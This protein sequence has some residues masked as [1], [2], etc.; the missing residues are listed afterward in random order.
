[1]MTHLELLDA[2]ENMTGVW[3]WNAEPV[4]PTECIVQRIFPKDSGDGYFYYTFYV[5]KERASW[6]TFRSKELFKTQL[7]LLES[8]QDDISRRIQLLKDQEGYGMNLWPILVN[9]YISGD[10]N[11]EN[12]K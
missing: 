7:E 5:H 10:K 1:M 4:E 12:V 11:K 9:A 3:F 2:M 8:K 6:K